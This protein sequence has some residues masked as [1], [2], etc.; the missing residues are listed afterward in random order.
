M[1]Y[2]LEGA[3]VE[4]RDDR[5]APVIHE[6]GGISKE[7]GGVTHW[8]ENE[9]TKKVKLVAIDLFNAQPELNGSTADPMAGQGC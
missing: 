9:G 4:H 3:I 8:W 7:S 6:A 1:M 2:I 5:D